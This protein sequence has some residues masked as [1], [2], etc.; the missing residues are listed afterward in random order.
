MQKHIQIQIFR[1]CQLYIYINTYIKKEGGKVCFS[2]ISNRGSKAPV[3]APQ[4]SLFSPQHCPEEGTTA[5]FPITLCKRKA[6]ST[7]A[8]S[9]QAATLVSLFSSPQ[10]NSSLKMSL[11]NLGRLKNIICSLG[12]NDSCSVPI[13]LPEPLPCP[14]PFV[15]LCAP[16]ARGKTCFGWGTDGLWPS[17]W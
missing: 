4:R 3:T 11:G 5:A 17:C 14:T 16:L 1:T 13:P 9:P 2:V 6:A 15:P 8:A 7:G 10:Y 12:R